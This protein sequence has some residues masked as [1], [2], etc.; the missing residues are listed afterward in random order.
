MMMKGKR[1]IKSPMDTAFAC[2]FCYLFIN[3]EARETL[4]RLMTLRRIF[5]ANRETAGGMVN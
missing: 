5:L 3:K 4:D 1:R 2:K